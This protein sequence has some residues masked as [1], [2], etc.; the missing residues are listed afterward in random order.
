MT[1][2]RSGYAIEVVTR[3]RSFEMAEVT[4]GIVEEAFALLLEALE[5]AGLE[6]TPAAPGVHTD[7]LLAP[8]PGAP[9]ATF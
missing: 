4:G 6:A 3:A 9:P 7:L 5:R 2:V 1:S 8:P